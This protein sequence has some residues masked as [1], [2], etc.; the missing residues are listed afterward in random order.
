MREVVIVS[1]VRT[2]VGSFGGSLKDVPAVKLGEIV[3]KT[4]MKRA[5]VKPEQIEEV[6]LGNVLTTAQGQN[7]AR[8]VLIN[9]GIPDSVPAMT[10]NKVCA[11]GMRAVTLATQIIG[12]GDADI[13]LA[14]GIEN[15]SWAPYVVPG[16][17]WGQRMNDGKIVD[18]MV[19]DGL[20]EVFNGY[21]MGITAENLAEKYNISREEQDE[22]SYGSQMKAKEAIENGHFE[23]E[24]EPVEIPQRRGDPIV[25]KVDEHVK[26]KTTLEGLAKLRP[27]FKKDGTVT[28]G[29]AS[30]INDAAAALVIMSADKAKELGLSPMAKIV[31]Y[32]SGG[33]DPKYMGLGPVPATKKALAKTTLTLDDMD[34]LEANEAFAS[35]AL[36]VHKELN[37]NMDKVN[38]CGGA[39]AIGH[40]IGCSGARILTTLLY[41]LK[42][43]GGSLGL[44]T[45]CVGGGM[46][47][48]TIVEMM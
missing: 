20:W 32:A 4:A 17:R 16:A 30:G 48:T 1:A 36:S 38:L 41:N 8:Q 15:M 45:L 5:E 25:F 10:V 22:L 19:Y 9:S 31:S 18:V 26:P 34:V 44:A 33:V 27:A 46:G 28:A 13:I 47:V 6:I 23:A 39:I 24:I 7:P 11:S 42:R 40:P 3:A 29:N 43:T 14:G 37:F 12:L 2:A 35:Q 21:H